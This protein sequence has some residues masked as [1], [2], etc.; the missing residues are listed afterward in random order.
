MTIYAILNISL[1]SLGESECHAVEGN[2]LNR[3]LRLK[4]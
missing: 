3:F 1:H 4:F 2:R